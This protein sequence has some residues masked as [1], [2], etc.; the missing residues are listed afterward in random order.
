[1]TGCPA[2]INTFEKT[3]RR[4]EKEGRPPLNLTSGNPN[5]QGIFFPR[6]ILGEIYRDYFLTQSYQP[7]PKGLLRARRAISEYYSRQ[8]FDLNPE[9]IILTAGTSESFLYLFN[10]LGDKSNNILVPT[11]A[12]PLFEFIAQV[13]PI[14]LR[15]YNLLE[16]Q[17]WSVDIPSIKKATDAST[18]ALL[19]VSP[20]NPTGSV[21][22]PEPIE[23][24]TAWCNQQGLAL[25]CDEVFSEFY[26]GA[27]PYPRAASISKPQLCLTL[28]G[29]SKMFALPALKL[30]WIGVSGSRNRVE[31]AVDRLETLAD[32][33][34]SC[35]GPIQWALPKIF[36]EGQHFVP[37][38][39]E[40]VL[41]RRNLVLDLIKQSKYLNAVEPLGGFHLMIKVEDPRN[42]NEEEWVLQL[43]EN[44]GVLVHPG[45]FFDY[46]KRV[47]F[48]LSF[49]TEP[50]KLTEGMERIFGFVEESV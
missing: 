11:P 15:T 4:L 40:I 9:H 6:E 30:G 13:S 5:E 48:V 44:V 26:F 38:Y 27:G 19:L 17:A 8:D 47:H 21:T 50:K 24:I 31:P 23:E 7:H 22:S 25:I 43:M 28:N 39:R 45:Y 35:H 16:E 36:G 12:Y 46:E 37:N 33:F 29:I 10:L 2:P 3:R 1:M 42:R 20:N 32:T 41:Q 34:L 18:R 49:L 14:Q